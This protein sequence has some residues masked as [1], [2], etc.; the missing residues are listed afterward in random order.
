M[1]PR[2]RGT[3]SVAFVYTNA[4]VV[5][6][7]LNGKSLG[8]Q[9]VKRL[10][11][12]SWTFPYERGNL[13][14]VALSPGGTGAGSQ[15]GHHHDPSSGSEAAASDT[16]VT[17][18][19]ATQLRLTVDVPS[20]STGTG[21]RLLADGA[22]AGLVR[23]T[24]LDAAGNVAPDSG[25]NVS[26]SIV[27]GPG[28]VIGVGNGNPKCVEP[29]Q[30]PWRSSFRGKRTFSCAQTPRLSPWSAPIGCTWCVVCSIQYRG[31]VG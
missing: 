29:N 15:V 25:V 27:D 28:R 11:Y 14:A 16:V 5:E 22:D 19:P 30:V 13:T 24:L 26:F 8:H 18:G 6:L 20:V 31:G 12:A 7:F 10:G 3:P 2:P 9:A 4:P 1:Q 17:A 23:V 21:D